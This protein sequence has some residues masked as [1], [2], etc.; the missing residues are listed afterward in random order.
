MIVVIGTSFTVEN[1]IKGVWEN[2]LGKI[3]EVSKS[4]GMT[5]EE[6][7][8]ANVAKE[9]EEF[10]RIYPWYEFPFYDRF[11]NVWTKTDYNGEDLFRKW[12]RKMFLSSE[13]GGKAFYSWLIKLGTKSVYGDAE[14]EIYV[15]IQSPKPDELLKNLN[16]K[17][18]KK[19][20]D[21][22]LLVALPRYEK[23]KE[24]VTKLVDNKVKFLEIAGNDHILMTAVI[25]QASKFHFPHTKFLF[26]K[27]ILT[28]STLKRVAFE[29]Q[30]RNMHQA[31]SEMADNGIGVEHIYDF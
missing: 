24:A 17:V 28:D 29:L 12:E 25:P 15:W 10:I 21:S 20:Q 19:Y 27:P 31:L 5:Q 7:L 23:F 2:T 9:Y 6:T 8:A 4:G 16:L 13:Y 11:K 18:F 3:A 1:V 22:S 26:Q 14:E 30:V